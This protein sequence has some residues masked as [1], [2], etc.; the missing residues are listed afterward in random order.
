MLNRSS[1]LASLEQHFQSLNLQLF[2]GVSLALPVGYIIVRPSQHSLIH[3][4]SAL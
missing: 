4:C 3:S 2:L 1:K